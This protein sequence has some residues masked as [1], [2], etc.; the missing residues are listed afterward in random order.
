[1]SADAGETWLPIS[2]PFPNPFNI[3]S[4]HEVV[5]AE[6]GAVLVAFFEQGGIFVSYNDGI[7]W[8]SFTEG[9][10]FETSVTTF[11]YN[12]TS[13]W[14]GTYYFGVYQRAVSDLTSLSAAAPISSKNALKIF[15]SPSQGAFSCTLPFEFSGEATL[16]VFDLQGKK[17]RCRNESAAQLKNVDLGNLASGIYVV[18]IAT[19]QGVFVGKV[20]L[21][22]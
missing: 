2:I 5:F 3:S 1:M 21:N 19:T 22:D 6:F 20:I 10:P 9:I 4:E 13:F 15:P 11:G 8:E 7:S 18:S 16:S 14:A 12:E 17:I